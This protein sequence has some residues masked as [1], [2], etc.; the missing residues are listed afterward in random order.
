[1][2]SPLEFNSLMEGTHN[3]KI[4]SKDNVGNIRSPPVSYTWTVDTIQ[5]VSSINSAIDGNNQ[6]L[7]NNDNSSSASIEFTFTY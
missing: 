6:T 3:L 4:F 1:M 2:Y 5:P 7:D